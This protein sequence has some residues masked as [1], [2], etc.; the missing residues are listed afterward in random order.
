MKK[1]QIPSC[2]VLLGM[3]AAAWLYVPTVQAQQAK[4]DS[5]VSKEVKLEGVVVKGVQRETVVKGDTT[6]INTDI[7]H[8]PEDAYLEDLIS[9]ISGVTYDKKSKEVKYKNH[10][11]NDII[12]DGKPFL[13]KRNMLDKLPAKIVGRIKIY[14]RLSDM[15]KFKG[16]KRTGKNYVMDIVMKGKFRGKLIGEVL[17]GKGNNDKWQAGGNLMRFGMGNRIN[18]NASLGNEQMTT[19]HPGNHAED[20]SFSNFTQV[21]KHWDVDFG[22]SYRNNVSGSEST[23][24]QEQYLNSGNRFM[25]AQSSQENRSKGLSAQVHAKYKSADKWMGDITA[26]TNTSDTHSQNENQNATFTAQPQLD[27]V[28]PFGPAFQQAADSIRLNHIRRQTASDAD[29]RNYGIRGNIA[30]RFNQYVVGLSA[31]YDASHAK[32][33]SQSLSSTRFYQ[34]VSALG[35]DSILH[36]NLYD[37]SPTSS[38]NAYVKVELT[39]R[40][41]G[42]SFNYGLSYQLRYNRQRS[43]RDSYDLAESPFGQLPENYTKSYVDSL[44]NY[45]RQRQLTHEFALNLSYSKNGKL[46]NMTFSV[47]PERRTLEQKTGYVTADTVRHAVNFSNSLMIDIPL[48]KLNIGFAY[49]GNTRQ[50]SLSDLMVMTDN[51][52]PLNIR[53]GNPALKAAYSQNVTLDISPRM[54]GKGSCSFNCSFS[55]VIND[56]TQAVVYHPATGVRETYPD[57]ING[58]W[59]ISAMLFLQRRFGQLFNASMNSSYT[60]AQSVS[61]VNEGQSEQAQRSTTHSNV[62]MVNGRMDVNPRW[63]NVYCSGNWSLANTTNRFHATSTAIRTYLFSLGGFVRLPWNLELK[64]DAS[65]SFR[66]GTYVTPGQDDV[67][68]WNASLSHSFLKKKKMQVSLQW[69]DILSDRKDFSRSVTATELSETH[70]QQ[71]GGYIM[72]ALKYR[73]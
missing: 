17:A 73:L 37:D 68:A 2:I 21:N 42:Q 58:N 32:S 57:N 72:A 40:D 44:S 23:L 16:K 30:R 50:P 27:I 35:G 6:I 56:Q 7:Y 71:I 34:M 49:T 64:T 20:I 24:Y 14:D 69:V 10:V 43:V 59:N 33:H 36:R 48:R 19:R 62:W 39:S 9:R 11:I 22:G 70:T 67:V 5:T 31:G 12:I 63:G 61:L 45:S 29:S 18:V 4:A 66:N 65:Y 15:D 55:N 52:D 53:H 3:M 54:Y 1:T 25:H 46:V 60:F 51:R 28:N 8:L 41:A 38:H 26:Q 47:L 13:S